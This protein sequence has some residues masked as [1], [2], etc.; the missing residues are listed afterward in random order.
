MK[1]TITLTAGGPQGCG[2]S[3]FLKALQDLLAEYKVT[4]T[5]GHD[6]DSHVLTCIIPDLEEFE[7]EVEFM[8]ESMR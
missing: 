2:K 6:P 1:T 5:F 7:D 4:T 8:T 3:R